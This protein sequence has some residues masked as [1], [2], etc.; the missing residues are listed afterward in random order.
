MAV[1]LPDALARIRFVQIVVSPRREFRPLRRTRWIVAN[2]GKNFAM[3]I[4]RGERIQRLVHARDRSRGSRADRI[5][6][7]YLASDFSFAHR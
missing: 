7:K 3:R 1:E 4:P 5:F 2:R 6:G